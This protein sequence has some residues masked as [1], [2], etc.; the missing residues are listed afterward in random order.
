MDDHNKKSEF[1]HLD[2]ITTHDAGKGDD[3]EMG[4]TRDFAAMNSVNANEKAMT[5]WHGVKRYRFALFYCFSVSLGAMLNGLDASVSFPSPHVTR[6]TRLVEGQVISIPTFRIAFGRQIGG[7][8]VVPAG[9]QSAWSGGQR[10]VTMIAAIFAG[11]AA[12][13]FG[14][15]NTL[16]IACVVSI[17]SIFI[18]YYAKYQSFGMIPAG[19]MV[20]G[21]ASGI[22]SSIAVS[23][24]SELAPLPVRGLTVGGLNCWITFGQL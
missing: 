15:R 9:W 8:Y 1:A 16:L 5:Y 3:Y 7:R 19:R 4:K 13:T 12:D 20:N 17:G 24:T 18:L 23:Y 11:Q 22:F 10:A 14:R 2:D 21:A 6:L